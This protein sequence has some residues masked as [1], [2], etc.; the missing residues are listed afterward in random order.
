MEGLGRERVVSSVWGGI[1]CT[2]LSCAVTLVYV[3]TTW[4]QPHRAALVA[5]TCGGAAF[6]AF[7]ALLPFRRMI[8]GSRRRE[9]AFA[10]AWNTGVVVLIAVG[11]A[12]DGGV[13]SPLS[14]LGFVPVVFASVSYSIT[15]LVAA[16]A[17]SDLASFLL[18]A[19]LLG[20]VPWPY[21]TLF[22]C[23][24][25]IVAGTCVWQA[26]RGR[27]QRRELALASRTDPLTGCLNRRG[28]EERLALAL[29]QAADRR[30]TLALIHLDFDDF[31]SVN[32][33]HGHAA[34]DALLVEAVRRM[35]A[36]LR[37][38]DVLGRMGGDEFAVVA[39]RAD[40]RVGRALAQRV[41]RS[42]AP[43]QAS[44]GIALF[45]RDG[46]TA[47]ELHR[48]ADKRMYAVKRSRATVA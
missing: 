35:R 44:I 12:L 9:I 31:K 43:S 17:V 36:T 37:E 22:L 30:E 25:T 29:E 10:A 3:A 33:T 14:Y 23:T 41:G 5:L 24:L 40:E 32:D 27:R 2:L 20:G 1:W 47:D 48:A 46:R 16:I 28:L 34:G 39:L 13:R 38:G 4:H 8:A 18:V 45:P 42:I 6:G 26:S 15:L 11:A 7:A 19:L 21:M